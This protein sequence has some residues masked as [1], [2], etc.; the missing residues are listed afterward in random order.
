[1]I[2]IEVIVEKI[3]WAFGKFIVRQFMVLLSLIGN[4]YLFNIQLSKYHFHV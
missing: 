3:F 4:V 1:M 2:K